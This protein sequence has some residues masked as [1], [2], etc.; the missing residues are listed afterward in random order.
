MFSI[1]IKKINNLG[2]NIIYASFSKIIVATEKH[3]YK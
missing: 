3:S 1:L 2:M